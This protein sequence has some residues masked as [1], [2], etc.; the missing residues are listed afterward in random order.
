MLEALALIGY[1]S[2]FH[3][4]GKKGAVAIATSLWDY[5]DWDDH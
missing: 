5:L 3:G 2:F 4:M 1:I